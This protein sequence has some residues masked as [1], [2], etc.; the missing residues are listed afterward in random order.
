MHPVPQVRAEIDR[1]ENEKE[2]VTGKGG[3]GSRWGMMSEEERKAAEEK[4]SGAG[5]RSVYCLLCRHAVV[6]VGAMQGQVGVREQPVAQYACWGCRSAACT[7]KF[8][9]C[10]MHAHPL[11]PGRRRRMRPTAAMTCACC[12]A[13]AAT[14]CAATPAPPPTMCG[15]WARATVPWAHPS[16]CA[17]SAVW[18]AAVSGAEGRIGSVGAQQWC[19]SCQ[20]AAWFASTLLLCCLC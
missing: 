9:L 8:Q 7:S 4:V 1:R 5:R 12:A 16:G 15:V 14:C 3:A 10:Y 13:A 18:A 6:W 11:A 19:Q 17:R 20:A 2:F